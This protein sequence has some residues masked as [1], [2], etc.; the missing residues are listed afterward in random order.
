MLAMTLKVIRCT[1]AGENEI[2]IFKPLGLVGST[3]QHILKN[4]GK[5][6][7]W[8]MTVATLTAKKLNNT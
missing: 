7:K 2:N 6:R 5:S 1:E 4:T 8:R 3:V